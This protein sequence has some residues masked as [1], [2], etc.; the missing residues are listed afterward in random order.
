MNNFDCS[1]TSSE[2]IYPKHQI[3]NNN[4]MCP[5][6]QS[7]NLSELESFKKNNFIFSQQK[8]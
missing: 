7:S 4:K 3:I 5:N 8:K 2:N 1:N 6:I